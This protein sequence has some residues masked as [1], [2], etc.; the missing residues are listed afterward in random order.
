MIRISDDE[1]RKLWRKN[2]PEKE[3]QYNENAKGRKHQWYLDNMEIT[4]ERANQWAK[5]HFKRRR[6]ISNKHMKK[7]CRLGRKMLGEKL[8]Y[9]LR[10]EQKVHHVDMN[11]FN[12][13]LEN[14]YVYE[15]QSEHMLGHGSLNRLVAELLV[16]K[17]IEFQDG[18]YV[19]KEGGGA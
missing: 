10:Y 5:D 16:K 3:K 13:D 7:R 11:D 14:L 1:V 18:K 2:N 12:N 15:S 8:G 17:I 9:Q 19:L 4:K 6:E